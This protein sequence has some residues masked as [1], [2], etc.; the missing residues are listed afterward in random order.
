MS[1]PLSHHEPTGDEPGGGAR[2]GLFLNP[3]LSLL[4]FHERVMLQATRPEIPLLERLRFLTISVTNLDEFFEVRASALRQQAIYGVG[5]PGADG[6]TP[7]EVLAEIAVNARRLVDAQYALLNDELL[8]ALRRHGIRVLPPEEWTDAQRAW[9]RAYFEGAILP[10][11]GA[12]A[13]DPA[14]PFPNIVNKRINYIVE[15]SGRDAFGREADVAI[16]PVP[17]PQVLPRVI[18]MPTGLAEGPW[19][20]VMLSDLIEAH[21]SALFPGM[22]VLGAHQFRLTRNSDLWVDEEEVDD[23]LLAI[24]GELPRRDF[25]DAVRLEVDE[26]IPEHLA[27]LLLEEFELNDDDLYRTDG[28]VNLH[29]V[30]ALHGEV[31]L[32]HLK[33]P[34][35]LPGLPPRLADGADLLGAMRQGDLLLHHPYQSFQP[36]IE[37]VQRAARDPGV[38]AIRMT[39]YRTGDDSPITEALIE[40]ARRG[41]DVTAIIELRARFDE[42]N[43]ID[44]AQRLKSAGANVAYGVVGRKTHAKLLHITRREGDRL[45]AYVHLGTGNY[46]A[47]T[48]TAYTDMGLLTCDEALAQDVADLFRQLTGLG[49]LPPPR[50]LVT[51]PFAMVDHFEAL[52][53]A[54]IDAARRGEPA[55]IKARMN[56]LA[57]PRIISAL[58]RASTAG[59]EIDLLVRGMCALRPGLPGV[60]DRIRVRSVVGRF[61]EH[62]RV[63]GFCGG[64][65]GRVWLASA[66]WLPRN[67]YRRVEVAFPVD[68]PT[69]RRRVIEEALDLYL[70]DDVDAWQLDADGRW[71][72][73]RGGEADGAARAQQ[74]LLTRHALV[75]R[76]R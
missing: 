36:V 73:V 71:H 28:P 58:Y 21:I 70:A 12:T 15:V 2:P 39:L 11:L 23:L 5:Y 60:S 29:R 55:W 65:E 67:L 9:T 46:H 66:D 54:E 35:F 62:T 24:A 19:D 64:G 13:L 20:F 49:Q 22:E 75:E 52:I 69:L 8:P 51:A 48:A 57:D 33:F 40:A 45:R 68:D 34:P 1:F 27:R 16:V 42:E 47:K 59:V 72:P 18:R 56:S 41:K 4:A 74:T 14:R 76:S 44:V 53:D 6:R 63:F 26:A 10:I 43:N 32:P 37:L 25:G 7:R 31:Q 30:S 38:L 61:L 17:G 50:K 3:E